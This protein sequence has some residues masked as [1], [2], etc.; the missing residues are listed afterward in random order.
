M[1]AVKKL[2][3][4]QDQVLSCNKQSKARG[5]KAMLKISTSRGPFEKMILSLLDLKILEFKIVHYNMLISPRTPE[6]LL[7]MYIVV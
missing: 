4:G 7:G 5:R 3:R 1:S 6:I 2:A